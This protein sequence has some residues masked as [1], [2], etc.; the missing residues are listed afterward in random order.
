MVV[1]GPRAREFVEACGGG[2][3]ICGGKPSFRFGALVPIPREVLEAGVDAR[4]DW[5]Y[6]NWGTGWD[7]GEIFVHSVSEGEAMLG[8]DTAWRPP[9]EWLA[10]VAAMYP[11]LSFRLS[12]FERG[13]FFAGSVAFAE[14][15]CVEDLH[16]SGIDAGA[17]SSFW[18]IAEQF[19]CSREIF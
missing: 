1:R 6:R 10:K 9:R 3:R 12:Y 8:L 14:G 15:R 17:E 11:D 4:L 2:G 5:A 18:E 16:V 13:M 7:P 19:G